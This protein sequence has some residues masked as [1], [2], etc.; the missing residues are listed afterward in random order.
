MAMRRLGCDNGI[1]NVASALIVTILDR[2]GGGSMTIAA[3]A[4]VIMAVRRP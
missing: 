1:T 4:L 3:C 2:L